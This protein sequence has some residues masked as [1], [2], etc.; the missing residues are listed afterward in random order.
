M[1]FWYVH[2]FS[3]GFDDCKAN[4]VFQGGA[5]EILGDLGVRQAMKFMPKA[6]L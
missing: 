6:V 1:L 3:Y 5:E 4:E 2:L